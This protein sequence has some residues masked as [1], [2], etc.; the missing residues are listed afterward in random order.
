[1]IKQFNDNSYVEIIKNDDNIVISIGGV[2][3]ENPRSVTVTTAE[4]TLDEFKELIDDI[5]PKP[6]KSK[7]PTKSKKK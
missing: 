2:D 5:I 1:M 3:I 4:V 6:V 7:K